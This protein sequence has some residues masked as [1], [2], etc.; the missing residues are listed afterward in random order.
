MPVITLASP[1]GGSGK[2]STALILA[3][4]LAARGKRVS[5]LDC[6]PNQPIVTWTSGDSASP[7]TV[8]GDIAE[9]QIL[10]VIDAER[11]ARDYVV[12][13]LEGAATRLH[14]RAIMRSDLVLVPVAPF[15]LDLAQA[16]RAVALVQEEEQAIGRSIPVAISFNR[17]NPAI[18]TRA[19]RQIG[20]ELAA[21]GVPMLRTHLHMRAAFASLFAYRCALDELDP[22][23]VNGVDKAIEN[24]AAFATEVAELV[25]SRTRRAAA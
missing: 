12:V 6:D 10:P 23:R 15:A 19:E 3:T 21:A 24:A 4:T 18:P 8:I 17:T 11:A 2:S 16:A 20:Q 1:K 22:E 9:S 5:L 14:S 13:D 25:A 7:I